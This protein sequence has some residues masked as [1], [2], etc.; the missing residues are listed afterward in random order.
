MKLQRI[1]YLEI[2]LRPGHQVLAGRFRKASQ[3]VASGLVN[4][5][6]LAGRPAEALA[7]AGDLNHPRLAE[8]TTP[9]IL[10][11][12]LD[13]LGVSSLQMHALIHDATGLSAEA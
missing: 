10:D 5:V 3:P 1:E 8:R 6:T 2:A 4:H 7:Q 13:A 12:T 9:E 11:Q